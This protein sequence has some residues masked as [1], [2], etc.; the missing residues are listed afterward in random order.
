MLWYYAYRNVNKNIRK[1]RLP[2]CKWI[3]EFINEFL[4]HKLEVSWI[5]VFSISIKI[6]QWRDGKYV[7][8][9]SAYE[10]GMRVFRKSP[11]EQI[12]FKLA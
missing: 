10:K 3:V 2:R 8:T 12:F 7:G 9:H 4:E 1:W 6:L 5:N 11:F